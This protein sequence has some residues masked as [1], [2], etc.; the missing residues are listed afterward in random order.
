MTHTHHPHWAAKPD[1]L[2]PLVAAAHVW[3]G[4]L[5]TLALH[6]ARAAIPPT[7]R[8]AQLGLHGLNI[9]AIFALLWAADTALRPT[10]AAPVPGIVVTPIPPRAIALVPPPPAAPR[11]RTS[12]RPPPRSEEVCLALNLYHEAR[13]EGLV[14]QVMVGYVT[15]NRTKARYRGAR[16]ICDTVYSPYQFSWTHESP[17]Q[18][19]GEELA[20]MRRV[21]RGVIAKRYRDRTQGAMHY[22]NP[23]VVTPSW[24]LAY[25]EVVVINGHRFMR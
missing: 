6:K 9:L 1:P 7:P 12:Q 11:L 8:A 20:P 17:R 24:R 18:P 13:G 23:A 10:P 14:G 4:I 19:T 22:Y 21:S 15:I 16:T 2:V 5:A 25:E 3:A